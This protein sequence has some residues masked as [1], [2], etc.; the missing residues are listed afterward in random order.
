M[1][2]PAYCRIPAF[3]LEPRKKHLNSL[4]PLNI[5]KSSEIVRSSTAKT[6]C[7][8]LLKVPRSEICKNGLFL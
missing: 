4:K 5:A 3:S 1:N 6:S 2:F 8:V 7:V